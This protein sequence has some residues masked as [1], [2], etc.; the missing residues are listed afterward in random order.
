MQYLSSKVGKPPLFF[1]KLGQHN[2]N[3]IEVSWV[4]E[5]Y[6]FECKDGSIW[7]FYRTSSRASLESTV[8][9]LNDF[10]TCSTQWKDRLSLERTPFAD[11]VGF[12]TGAEHGSLW[13]IGSAVGAGALGSWMTMS[14][15][16]WSSLGWLLA[17]GGFADAGLCVFDFVGRLGMFRRKCAITRYWS[18]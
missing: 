7:D 15:G 14:A 2:Y 10:L 3:L 8:A 6:H 12:V 9:T 11:V 13:R 18:P 5:G 17:M 4:A 16:W 1:L